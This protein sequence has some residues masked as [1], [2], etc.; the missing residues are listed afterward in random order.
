MTSNKSPDNNKEIQQAAMQL[1]IIEAELRQLEEQFNQVETKRLEIEK[2]DLS[3]SDMKN[4]KGKEGF[5]EIG[6]GIYGK[7]K[8]L[9]ESELLVNVGSGVYTIKAVEEVRKILQ[10]QAKE[11][12]RIAHELVNNIQTLSLQA[13][14]IQQRFAG[15]EEQEE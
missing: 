12:D 7:T 9:D 10:K 6:L 3:L 15:P 2:L 1:Q 14:L 13:Q 8:L 5:S 11:L 4:A